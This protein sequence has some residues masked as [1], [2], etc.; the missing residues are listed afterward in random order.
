LDGFVCLLLS[1]NIVQVNQGVDCLRG[2]EI[3]ASRRELGGGRVSCFFACVENYDFT[4]VP[5]PVVL[6]LDERSRTEGVWTSVV[7]ARA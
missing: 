2:K 3:G 6:R 7:F 1:R 5:F 4:R